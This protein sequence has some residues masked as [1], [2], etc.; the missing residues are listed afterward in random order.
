MKTLKDFNFKEKKVLVRCDFNV[1]LNEKGDI[2]DDFRIKKTIPTIEYLIENKAKVILMSHLG[3][4]KGRVVEG[5]RLDSVAKRLSELLNKKIVKLNNCVGEE[6]E[7]V[8]REMQPAEVV[9]LENIQFNPGETENDLNFSKTLASYADFFVLE[10]F[11]QAHRNYASI[12]GIQKYIPSAVGFLLEKELRI[13]GGLIKSPKKP[14]IAII[15]GK[16][17]ETKTKLI[18]TLSEI[19]DFIL[20]GGLIKKEIEEKG[21]KLKN[22][23]KIIKPVDSIDRDGQGF[24]I[25]PETAKLF[26]QKIASAKTVFWAGPL[27]KFEEEEFSKGTTEVAK[28]IIESGAFS[29]A[30]GGDTVGFLNKV[31][32]IDKFNHISTGGGAMLDFIVDGS[33]VGVEA[34]N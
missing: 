10:A 34:L 19:A 14:L 8:I 27:G 22:P 15:G 6:V 12:T 23:Q 4:P 9:L 3:R 30:G 11:G 1:P 29:I 28:A 32:L 20:V 25:G 21:I 26:K 24:D 31:N 2:L 17:V 7:R 18:D 16:K 33:L 13:L 5:L